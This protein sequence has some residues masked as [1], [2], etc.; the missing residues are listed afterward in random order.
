MS[1]PADEGIDL[2]AMLLEMV[3]ENRTQYVSSSRLVEALDER[4]AVRAQLATA[5]A[6]ASQQAQQ[7]QALTEAVSA[8]L[9]QSEVPRDGESEEDWTEELDRRYMVM[10]DLVWPDALLAAAAEPPRG[11]EGA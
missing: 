4:D 2:D 5:E 8:F 7:I 1:E 6:R 9:A 11:V 10:R 3:L